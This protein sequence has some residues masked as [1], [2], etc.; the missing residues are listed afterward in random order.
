MERF[1]VGTGRCGSTLLSTMLA[2][3]DDVVSI[4]EFLSNLDPARRFR[5]GPVGGDDVADLMGYEQTVANDVLARG[6]TAPEVRYPFGSPHAR[7]EPGDPVPVLLLSSIP[8]LGAD[9]DALFADFVAYSRTL[10]TQ[11]MSDH[12]RSLF[13]WLARHA[14]GSIWVERSGSS[15]DFL[16]DL[17]DLYPDGRFVHLHRDGRE[18]ALSMREFPFMRLGMAVIFGLFP[19]T[20][21]EDAAVRH[22]LETPTPLWAAGRYWSD[23][24]LHG[25][26]A[27]A[28]LDRDQYLEVRFEDLLAEPR[29]VLEQVARHFELTFDDML[30]SRGAA[31]VRGAGPDRFPELTAAEQGELETAVR[32]G[33]ILLGRDG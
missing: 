12:Y 8:W 17:V 16:G 1:L 22:A 14:G 32:P 29:P 4:N 25:M 15:V 13:D 3:H 20:D 30:A 23:Q 19:D 9:P 7:H 21:D 24:L 2:E 5:P 28:R 33:Q 10:P 26:S 31:L 11:P 6:Y 18:A 27:V